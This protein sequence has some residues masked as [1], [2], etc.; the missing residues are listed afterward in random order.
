MFSIFF[1]LLFSALGGT[2]FSLVCNIKVNFYFRPISLS[3]GG[4]KIQK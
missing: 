1:L 4:G 2:F 3:F